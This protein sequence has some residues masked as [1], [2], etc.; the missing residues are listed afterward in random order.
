MEEVAGSV[1]ELVA[2][3]K[4]RFFGLGSGRRQYPARPR[5]HGEKTG[6]SH[7]SPES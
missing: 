6:T 4:V 2:A 1:G 5:R 3:G 7:S